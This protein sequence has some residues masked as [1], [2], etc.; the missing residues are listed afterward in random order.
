MR[1]LKRSAS[2][3]NLFRSSRARA[4]PIWAHMGPKNPKRY[5][6][7]NHLPL[8]LLEPLSRD[9]EGNFFQRPILNPP[10]WFFRRKERKILKG[11]SQGEGYPPGFPETERNLE[12]QRGS[13]LSSCSDAGRRKEKIA[14]GVRGGGGSTH[15]NP[16][17][18]KE[19]WNPGGG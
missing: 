4:G 3:L 14:R 15:M 1:D 17:G 5:V 16:S 12:R 11:G 2:F 10:G 7:Q 9:S 13:R 6:K 8:F 18:R 19:R